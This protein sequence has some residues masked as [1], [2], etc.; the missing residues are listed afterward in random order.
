ML[1]FWA[2]FAEKLLE[3]VIFYKL[4]KALA[5]RKAG[6]EEEGMDAII[7][8][9]PSTSTTIR[10]GDAFNT[11]DVSNDDEVGSQCEGRHSYHI[12]TH[13]LRTTSSIEQRGK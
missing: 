8:N 6:N 10:V 13:P 11:D 5:A 9:H 4:L 3:L 1:L 12:I 7:V 2:L